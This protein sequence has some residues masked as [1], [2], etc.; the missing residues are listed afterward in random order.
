MMVVEAL[1][2]GIEENHTT[3][4]SLC[5]ATPTAHIFAKRQSTARGVE[6]RVTEHLK[7]C[8]KGIFGVR[9]NKVVKR[10]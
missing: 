9:R 5:V 2:R 8:N 3:Q 4:Y 6:A 7:T 10:V 1:V